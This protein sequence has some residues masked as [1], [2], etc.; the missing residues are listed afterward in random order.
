VQLGRQRGALDVRLGTLDTAV[1]ADERF[2]TILLLGNN[3]GLLSGERQGRACGSSRGSRLPRGEFSRAFTIRTRAYPSSPGVTTHGTATAASWAA[4][5]A[6]ASDIAS[7]QRLG[8]T[9]SLPP[10]KSSHSS[11]LR[12]LDRRTFPRQQRGLRC[13]SRPTSLTVG[14]T[15]PG[16]APGNVA[17]RRWRRPG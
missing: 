9:C 17:R 13:R 15:A 3:L 2:D 11:R 14:R 5:N 16:A 12:G 1:E 10:G 6:S 8:T 7:L 4:W